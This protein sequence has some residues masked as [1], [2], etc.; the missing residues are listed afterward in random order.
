M[1]VRVGGPKLERDLTFHVAVSTI[2]AGEEMVD[3][4]FIT[5]RIA[6][7]RSANAACGLTGALLISGD[8]MVH[9]LEGTAA[10]IHK[11]RWHLD[12]EPMHTNVRQLAESFC[13]KRRFGA[14]PLAYVPSSRWVE[15]ALTHHALTDMVP[16][17]AADAQFLIDLMLDFVGDGA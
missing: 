13:M 2:Q 1:S 3:H 11:Q 5:A 12:R 14:W 7:W 9:V 6:T 17:S 10:A 15:R 16:N 4:D 8:E